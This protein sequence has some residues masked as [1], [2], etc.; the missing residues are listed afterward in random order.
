VLVL[1]CV[2]LRNDTVH[3]TDTFYLTHRPEP[4]GSGLFLCLDFG[5]YSLP[6]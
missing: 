2:H 5:S 3:A 4:K 1:H 6:H